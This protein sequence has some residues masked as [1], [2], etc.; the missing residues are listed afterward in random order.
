MDNQLLVLIVAVLVLLFA[1]RLV[2]G[3]FSLRGLVQGLLTWAAIGLIGFIA[4][5]HQR[6]IAAFLSR[7]SDGIGVEKQVVEGDTVR[8]PMSRDGHFWAKVRINGIE[9]RMLIDSGATITA[10]S[11]KTAAES[12]I[13]PGRMPVVLETAN[14]SIQAQSGRADRVQIGPLLTRNLDVVVAPNFGEFD[15]LGMN[16]LSRLKSWRVEGDTLVL[17]PVKTGAAA[18]GARKRS[19]SGADETDR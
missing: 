5:T 16:F 3:G 12:A 1:A 8:I 2:S 14:G 11:V 6:E 7:V 17:E 18:H 10:I 15:V 19:K 9:R 4:F 13:E